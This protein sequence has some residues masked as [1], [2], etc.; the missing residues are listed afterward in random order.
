MK[1]KNQPSLG[2]FP[3][4]TSTT[5]C[6]NRRIKGTPKADLALLSGIIF[7][8]GLVEC[9]ILKGNNGVLFCYIAF[10]FV[11]VIIIIIAPVTT[12]PDPGVSKQAPAPFLWEVAGVLSRLKDTGKR[13]SWIVGFTRGYQVSL[14]F[15]VLSLSISTYPLAPGCGCLDLSFFVSTGKRR[16]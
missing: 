7:V 6:C 13:W 2:H 16:N 3:I 11:I 14:P 15:I 4:F 1:H 12:Q 9:R 5:P 10:S 8:R